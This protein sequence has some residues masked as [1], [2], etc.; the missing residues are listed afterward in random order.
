[1]IIRSEQMDAMRAQLF[2][3]MCARLTQRLQSDS[4]IRGIDPARIAREVPQIL[5]DA[6]PLAIRGEES[7][8]RLLRFR[9]LVDPLL[10]SPLIQSVILRV[11]HNLAW[12]ADKRLGFLEEQLLPRLKSKE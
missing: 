8:Y 7:A 6:G 11:L 5:E 3:V 2:K 1:M 10:P 4:E 12:P 9:F